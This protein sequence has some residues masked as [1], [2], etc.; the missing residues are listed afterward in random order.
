MGPLSMEQALAEE[1]VA[2]GGLMPELADRLKREAGGQESA[3]E[4]EAADAIVE[5]ATQR[6]VGLIVMSS[7][8]HGGLG[9]LIFGSTTDEVEYTRCVA[10][11][12]SPS[13]AV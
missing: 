8:G 7:H 3:V 2:S 13:F 12:K 11:R 1:T 4:G 5:V 6:N 9:R 10:F